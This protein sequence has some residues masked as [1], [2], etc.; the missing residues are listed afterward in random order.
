MCPYFVDSLVQEMMA[1]KESLMAQYESIA[2]QT[3][4]I[5]QAQKPL[6]QELNEVK[7]KVEEF[8]GQRQ[9]AQVRAPPPFFFFFFKY[10]YPLPQG[11]VTQAAEQRLAAQNEQ[12]H[13]AKKL[14]DEEKKVRATKEQLDVVQQEFEVG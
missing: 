3:A 9:E 2:E 13:W 4:V 5:Q 8:D 12:H 10:I 11:R 14:L 1:E 7:K 6:L